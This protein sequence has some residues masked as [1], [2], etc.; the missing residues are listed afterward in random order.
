MR[1]NYRRVE[2]RDYWSAGRII[3]ILPGAIILPNDLQYVLVV[4]VMSL[5]SAAL[6]S[7]LTELIWTRQTI[8]A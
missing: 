3:S 6:I 5:S 2:R 1:G 4:F 7:S 8:D